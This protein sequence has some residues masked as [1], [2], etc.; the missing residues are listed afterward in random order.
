MATCPPRVTTNWLGSEFMLQ[1]YRAEED[2]PLA[3]MMLE[4]SLGIIL[5]SGDKYRAEGLL[6]DSLSVAKLHRDGGVRR[7][8]GIS[9]QTATEHRCLPLG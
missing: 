8:W 6:C 2:T 4:Y 7:G 3:M 1:L 5:S 9:S